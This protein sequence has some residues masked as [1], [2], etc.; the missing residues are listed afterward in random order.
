MAVETL[1]RRWWR[2]PAAQLSLLL[3][4]AAAVQGQDSVS[5]VGAGAGDGTPEPASGTS[6]GA[7]FAADGGL[8]TL[9]VFNPPAV[10]AASCSRCK[11]LT[12]GPCQDSASGIC[13]ALEDTGRCPDGTLDCR[14]PPCNP[15]TAG[16][17]HSPSGDCTPF[18]EGS[19]C[20][21]GTRGACVHVRELHP[22]T[23]LHKPACAHGSM[24]RASWGT[25]PHVG[26]GFGWAP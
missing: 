8:D 17:C 10:D 15:G 16:P 2:R 23:I 1:Q 13:W 6:D 14:C 5:G 19:R 25:V 3:L 12:T 26:R 21:H 7:G 24:C 18:V 20:A 11:Y 9:A 4:L 22:N